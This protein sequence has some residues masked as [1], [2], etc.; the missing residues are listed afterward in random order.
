VRAGDPSVEIGD[1]GDHRAVSVGLCSSGIIAAMEAQ[2]SGSVQKRNAAMAEI[3]FYERAD[4]RLRHGEQSPCRLGRAD[5]A[6]ERFRLCG[7]GSGSGR[8]RLRKSR[9]SSAIRRSR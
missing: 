2:T 5:G 7:A 8:G 1:G 9:A 3:G 6:G 4:D